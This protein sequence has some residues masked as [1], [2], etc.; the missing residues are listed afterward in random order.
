MG[1]A[2]WGFVVG[3]L[4]S[5]ALAGVGV[6][7]IA[8]SQDPVSLV[9]GCGVLLLAAVPGWLLILTSRVGSR[10]EDAETSRKNARRLMRAERM[11]DAALEHLYDPVLVTDGRGRVVRMNRAAETLFGPMPDSARKP[12]EEVVREPRI[13]RAIEAAVLNSQTSASEDVR[14]FVTLQ[15]P[16]RSQVYRV[17]VTP[18]GDDEG[19]PIGS[20]T[21][22]EDVTQLQ[23][24]DRLKTEFIGVAAHE[25]RTPV[26]SLMLSAE[27]LEEGAV[28]PLNAE[29]REIVKIQREDLQRLEHLMRDLLDVTRLEAGTRATK[30][31]PTDPILLMES[32][33]RAVEAQ[34]R[35]KGVD[36]AVETSDVPGSLLIDRAQIQRVL[37]NLLANA[38]RHTPSGGRVVVG[39]KAL[40]DDVTF[41]VRDTGEGIPKDYLDRIFERFV[42]VPGATQG[43][44]GLGLSIANEIVKAHGGRMSV[45]SEIGKGSLFSFTLP[46][47]VA[48]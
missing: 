39:S 2:R 14:S 20:V 22:L 29:Q 11:S 46:V 13:V 42:Q 15:G 35:A 48:R 12:V 47:G 26:S 27:L 45:Q 34:A 24:L 38:V 19:N 31:E 41:W 5:V 4:V 23:E 28:G 21:V 25:L 43:G 16:A 17:R 7:L 30:R 18:M 3:W 8:T 40:A 37:T 9:L 44:A 36:L 6:G 1:G 10:G 33:V 32:A